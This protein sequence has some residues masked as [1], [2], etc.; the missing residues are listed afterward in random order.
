VGPP[1]ACCCVKLVDVPEMEYYAVNGQGE[2][3]VK[4]TNVFQ[5][6]YKEDEKTNETI[7]S[8][9]WHHT[10]DVGMWL[11]VSIL[12]TSWVCSMYK[13][14]RRGHRNNASSCLYMHMLC[15]HMYSLFSSMNLG[16]VT[17][18]PI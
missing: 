12:M 14:K 8:D 16:P 18:Y 1:V 15:I 2:V 11:P 5:G 13:H 4:G 6:Y 9:G 10:G 17:S 3:C 7:D